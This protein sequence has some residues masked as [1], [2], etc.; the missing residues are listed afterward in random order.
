MRYQIKL[1][2]DAHP[3]DGGEWI[4]VAGPPLSSM[5]FRDYETLYG[6]Y[7][8]EGFHIVAFQTLTGN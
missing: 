6:A 8:P 4:D 2:P 5:K 1:V 3:N 7:I